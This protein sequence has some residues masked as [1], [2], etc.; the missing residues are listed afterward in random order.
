MLPLF[1]GK[2]LYGALLPGRGLSTPACLL[3][4]VIAPDRYLCEKIVKKKCANFFISLELF[5]FTYLKLTDNGNISNQCISD[6]F[7]RSGSSSGESLSRPSCR[8]Q[9]LRGR[10][11]RIVPQ[12]GWSS[13]QVMDSLL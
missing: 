12:M 11:G 5:R 3:V 6:P 2:K 1:G 9:A 10:G 8:N 7:S 4:L 13:A